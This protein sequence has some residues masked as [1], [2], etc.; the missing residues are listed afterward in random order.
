MSLWHMCWSL[1]YTL[2]L[3]LHLFPPCL[4]TFPMAS[5]SD[6]SSRCPS[7]ALSCLFLPCS[8][9]LPLLWVCWWE[10]HGAGWEMLLFPLGI[11]FVS[12]SKKKGTE[13]TYFWFA[14]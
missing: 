2:E 8:K 1:S 4:N 14:S 11:H 13:K 3:S 9:T 5:G 12:L 10:L 7:Q 6:H